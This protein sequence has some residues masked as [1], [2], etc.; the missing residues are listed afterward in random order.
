MWGFHE[1][2]GW[3]MVFGGM[4]MVVFWAIIIGVAVWAIGHFRTGHSRR[5]DEEG[6]PLEIAR[7]RL[8]KGEITRE[9]F[10]DLRQALR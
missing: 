4:W 7:Q 10:E 8:A 1:G 9:E 6:P 2:M 5:P 3:W